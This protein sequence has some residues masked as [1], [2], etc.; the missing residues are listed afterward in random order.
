MIQKLYPELF[1]WL[2]WRSGSPAD[3]FVRCDEKV[4]ISK[5]EILKYYAIGY[6]DGERLECRPKEN[7]KA[8][9]FYKDDIT[10]WFHLTNFEFQEVFL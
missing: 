5:K 9:M 10:F 6:C 4:L 8:V 2:S 1:D 7:C 3:L